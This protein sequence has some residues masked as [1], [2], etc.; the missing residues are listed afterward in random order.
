MNKEKLNGIYKGINLMSRTI[1]GNSLKE[2]IQAGEVVQNASVENCGPI[3]YDFVL[4]EEFLKAEFSSPVKMSDLTAE[5]KRKALVNPG[6][7]VYVLTRETINIPKNMYMHLSANR[8]MSEYG[9]LTLGGFAVDPG[10]SGRLMFGL[11]N[12]TNTP[13][14]LVPGAKLVGGVFY[15]FDECEV[16]DIEELEFSKSINNF[17]PRL[18]SIINKYSPTGLTTLED[19]IKTINQQMEKLKQETNNNR[20]ELTYLRR[21]VEDTQEQMNRLSRNVNEIS[22]GIT[23]L[24]KSVSG[25]KEE[26]KNLYDSLKEEANLRKKIEEDLDKKLNIATKEIDGKLA[27]IKGAT[28]VLSAGVS[29]LIFVVTGLIQGWLKFN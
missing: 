7:V 4:S 25:L 21:Y 27:F 17:P 18:I 2:L 10:Y 16:E 3:K 19:A 22:E 13:F 24:S 28:W 29:I 11:Y 23:D 20:D 1:T 26:V 6:E 15:Q 14:T 8:S 9:V 12:F 5:E